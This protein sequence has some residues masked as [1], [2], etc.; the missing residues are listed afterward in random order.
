MKRLK[1][2]FFASHAKSSAMVV[3]LV[4]HA[5]LIVMAASFVAVK[6]YQNQAAQFTDHRVLR[7]KAPLKK[8]QIPVKMK[9]RKP[10]PKLRK[11][12]TVKNKMNQKMPAIKMPDIAGIKTGVGSSVGGMGL[13]AASV[14]FSMPEINVFNVKTKGE[15]VFLILDSHPSIMDDS[16]GGILAYTI[17]KNEMIRVLESLPSTTLF[18]VAVFEE[19][20]AVVRFPR[21]VPAN[22]EN[23]KKVEEWLAP[24]NKAEIKVNAKYGLTTL[25]PGGHVIEDIPLPSSEGQGSVRTAWDWTKPLF[26]AMREQADAVFLLMAGRWGNQYYLL[27]GKEVKW[28]NPRAKKKWEECYQEGLKKLDEENKRRVAKGMP[29]RILDRN[30]PYEIN[31]AYF[32]DIERPPESP[33]HF[34]TPAEIGKDLEVV[35]QRAL[36]RET[37]KATLG[38]RKKK[39]K[40]DTLSVNVILFLPK[41]SSEEGR[42]VEKSVDKFKKLSSTLNGRYRAMTGLDAIRHSAGGSVG[43]VPEDK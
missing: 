27:E 9:K 43:D 20:A 35:H 23:L 42:R 21:M 39:K 16:I 10:K 28:S 31:A 33:K 34:Y 41:D 7:P 30:N 5:V 14:G 26:E 38:L 17:I 22:E 40:K 1:K 25:G 2:R 4:V 18:N 36:A 13:G 19:G 6:V 3:S 32:P 24:L 12:L 15:K 8:P 11:R 37:S 29:P